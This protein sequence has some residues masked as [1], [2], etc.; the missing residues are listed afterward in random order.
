LIDDDNN[1]TVLYNTAHTK[2]CNMHSV[3]QLAELEARTMTIFVYMSCWLTGG[4]ISSWRW[5]N[6]DDGLTVLWR[7]MRST[8]MS[9][10]LTTASLRR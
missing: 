3:C 7:F 5:M 2:L 1:D 8:V 9:M 6:T 4:R 10:I